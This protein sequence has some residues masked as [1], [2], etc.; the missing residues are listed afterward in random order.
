MYRSESQLIMP[1]ITKREL[2]GL[3][4]SFQLYMK[5]PEKYHKLVEQQEDSSTLEAK[6]I[7]EKILLPLFNKIQDEESRWDI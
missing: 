7:R 6:E 4:S 5:L 3:M 1:Q 2:R